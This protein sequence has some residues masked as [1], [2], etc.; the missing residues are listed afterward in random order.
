MSRYTIVTTL[1]IRS[2][3]F[4]AGKFSAAGE[5]SMNQSSDAYLFAQPD[6]WD[7]CQEHERN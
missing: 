2:G 4:F 3:N 1:L 6:Q 5:Q 7:A